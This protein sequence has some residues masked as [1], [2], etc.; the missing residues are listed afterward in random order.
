MTV[1]A[2]PHQTASGLRAIGEGCSV[3]RR[4][5]VGWAYLGV[6]IIDIQINGA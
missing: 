2:G 5:I 4:P 3:S 1:N 6:K